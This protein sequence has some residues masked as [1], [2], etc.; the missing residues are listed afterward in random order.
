MEII[1]YLNFCFVQS[2]YPIGVSNRCTAAG[3][4]RELRGA[5]QSEVKSGALADG[6]LP[7]RRGWEDDQQHPA[8]SD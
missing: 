2:V 6:T 3:R 4:V 7:V 5:D 1:F 8:T